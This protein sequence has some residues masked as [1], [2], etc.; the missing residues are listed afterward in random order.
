MSA[1]AGSSDAA[2]ALWSAERAL[3]PSAGEALL[4]WATLVRADSEQVERLPNRPRLPDFYAPVAETF[5]ADPRREDDPTLDCLRSLA[6]PTETWL[7]LGAGGGRFTLAIALKAPRVYAIEPSEGMRA[8][9][10][11]AMAEHGVTNIDVFPERWP[12]PSEAPVA[13]VGF[14]SHVSYDIADI[15]PF[16]GELE[17][18]ARRLCVAVLFEEAP[19][20]LFAPLWEPVH[21]EARCLLPGLREFVT[22]LFA[23]GRTP[24]IRLFPTRQRTFPD[25]ETLQRA[26]RR[27]VWVEEGSPEDERLTA[28]IGRLAVPA[29]AGFTLPGR[30]PYVGVVTWRPA[31]G[32]SGLAEG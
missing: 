4:A 3:R 27:A 30:E 11:S 16:L 18:H 9:L 25:L 21:G 1:A 6:L 10:A 2:S 26:A 7:D 20:S 17:V 19:I 32:W 28:A 12:G 13:D 29:G 15:G 22:L 24:E 14:M 31:A 8:V 23:L 5:R